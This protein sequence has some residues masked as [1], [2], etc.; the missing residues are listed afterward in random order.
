MSVGTIKGALGKRGKGR[1]TP[2]QSSTYTLV[3]QTLE[4]SQTLFTQPQVGIQASDPL[5]GGWTR[6]SPTWEPWDYSLK[7]WGYEREGLEK[8]GSHTSESKHSLD[9]QRLSM[10]L[11]LYYRE[12]G[13][14][15]K[16]RKE[17]EERL[18]IKRVRGRE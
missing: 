18:E 12:G 9:E 16:G 5:F 14:K 7:P 2:H 13:G 6:G 10:V 4:G 3:R 15:R 11:E 1:P 8:R 17:R